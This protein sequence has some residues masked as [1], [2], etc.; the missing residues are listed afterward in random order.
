ML[1][2]GAVRPSGLR[3]CR[4]TERTRRLDGPGE[5]DLVRQEVVEHVHGASSAL[6]VPSILP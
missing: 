2:E 1:E 3:S 4:C 5:A 6:R